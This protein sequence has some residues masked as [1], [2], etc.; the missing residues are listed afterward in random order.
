M[1][2]IVLALTGRRLVTNPRGTLG[3]LRRKHWETV[4][5]PS[6]VGAISLLC[7]SRVGI[8]TM[9]ME[10]VMLTEFWT[11]SSWGQGIRRVSTGREITLCWSHCLINIGRLCWISVKRRPNRVEKLRSR[12]TMEST[13]C[14]STKQY[15]LPWYSKRFYDSGLST[16]CCTS[17]QYSLSTLQINTNALSFVINSPL[18]VLLQERQFSDVRSPR[19][20]GDLKR[21]SY[22]EIAPFQSMSALGR[23]V[24][25]N[26]RRSHHEASF[27]TDCYPFLPC[28]RAGDPV[29]KTKPASPLDSS[30]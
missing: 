18:S 24:N 15:N 28:Q 23:S 22:R 14:S 29:A 16:S 27:W 9:F 30:E 21:Q 26:K 17:I 13:Q 2:L 10:S 1:Y 7:Y 11:G 4:S 19:L 8:G 5:L 3:W 25:K 12:E 20:L 6:C